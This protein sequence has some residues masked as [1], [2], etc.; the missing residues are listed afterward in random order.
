MEKT[1][2]RFAA[3]VALIIVVSFPAVTFTV[4]FQYLRGTLESEAEING[5]IATSFVNA[6]PE[7]WQFQ[8]NRLEELLTR[9]PTDGV[10]EVR[11]I[12]D[13]DGREVAGSTDVLGTPL[14]VRTFAIR[15]SG[16]VV[17]H[18][19]VY[20][21]LRSLIAYTALSALL[22]LVLAVAVGLAVRALP[23][24]ALRVT[25]EQLLAERE[26]AHGQMLARQAAEVTAK[27]QSEFLA[28]MSHEIRT[29]MNGVLGM[30][31]LLLETELNDRQRRFADAI[32][33]SGDS[34][35]KIVNDIL[36][37]SKIDAGKLE[38]EKTDFDLRELVE[39][40]AELVAERA[41]AKGVEVICK[42]PPTIPPVFVGDPCR[43]RQ[44]LAN[45]VNNAIKFTEQGHVLIHLDCT[46]TPAPSSCRVI[47]RVTD[48]GVGICPEV[49]ARLF[50]P[51]VQADVSTTRKYGGTGLGL[52]ISQQLV[53]LMGGV[54]RLQSAIGEGST[55]SFELLFDTS[56]ARTSGLP[57]ANLEGLS[58]LVVEDNLINTAILNEHLTAWGMKND[59]A[60]DGQAGLDVL[61]AA[62]ARG[63]PYDMAL[64]DLKMPRMNGLELTKR[65]RDDPALDG[66]AIIMLTSLS[67]Q[68][69]MTAAR[70]AGV[71]AYV[72]KPIR[73]SELFKTLAAVVGRREKWVASA[74]P[75]AAEPGEIHA[76]VLLAEDNLV[77]QELAVAMLS[78]FGCNVEVVNNGRQAVEA[79]SVKDFDIVF[80]D[81]QM[82]E[83]DGFEATA[84]IRA[85][86]AGVAR[87]EVQIVALTANA[88]QGDRDRCLAAGMTDYVAKPL[89]K[90]ELSAV[91][92]RCVGRGLPR[93]AVGP[94]G[95]VAAREPVPAPVVN[96]LNPR[97]LDQIR[98]LDPASGG[99][100]LARV[101]RLY[102]ETAPALGKGLLAAA[103]S[104]DTAGVG[105]AAHSL[106]S[107]SAN[108]GADA[109]AAL[110]RRVEE[111]ATA[112]VV[113]AE[114]V[115]GIRQELALALLLV[116]GELCE[117]QP[118]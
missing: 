90:R 67:S 112:G 34:L 113:Q 109:L 62:A 110:C 114:A 111:S 12:V 97:A 4:G 54:I 55:F 49:A 41:Q 56:P 36:D 99:E 48:T 18:F 14:A 59:C 98:G 28:N 47:F 24:K 76:H 53:S 50:Q 61:R 27:L 46:E 25:L 30:T 2:S 68:G 75:K 82:P 87:K 85:G 69:E 100:L 66:L 101:G 86:A 5:R 115:E 79:V 11:R 22:G 52:A 1:L 42:I 38:M 77:N 92:L 71:C 106:K 8:S 83:M 10:K 96:G 81:C 73:Q 45:L 94:V 9:R 44:V 107:S 35:L 84:L 13:L 72:T 16:R 29:P 20:R 80:M 104:G 63:E 17:A 103:A 32:R 88:M 19:E 57:A 33:R 26:L 74:A 23:M 91:L 102:L 117:G 105:R 39:D 78:F 7:H 6:D 93:V 89:S 58:V 37:F 70:A 95:R 43:L 3:V 116:R 51:F 15:D 60:A 108:L 21:S 65:L 118:A 64:V 31:E 40:V